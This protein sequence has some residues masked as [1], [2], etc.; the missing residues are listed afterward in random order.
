[1]GETTTSYESRWHLPRKR[2]EHVRPQRLSLSVR[3]SSHLGIVSSTHRHRLPR[4]H[5][6]CV[7]LPSGR[8]VHLQKY[9]AIKRH[10]AST[11]KAAKIES[12]WGKT[13]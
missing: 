10:A 7:T 8:L 12:S 13:K 9:I 6:P 1:M 11:A 3:R 5:A 4:R 2:S